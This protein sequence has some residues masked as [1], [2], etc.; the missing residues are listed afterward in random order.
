[1]AA[2]KGQDLRKTMRCEAEMHEKAE[3][4]RQYVSISKANYH[5]NI[6]QR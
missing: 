6:T 1:M 4:T 3:H 2:R 5:Y